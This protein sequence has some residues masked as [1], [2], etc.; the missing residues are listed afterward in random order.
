[1]I[2]FE[3]NVSFTVMVVGMI[4]I[5][6]YIYTGFMKF[7]NKD[8]QI[9]SQSSHILTSYKSSGNNREHLEFTHEWKNQQ[10]NPEKAHQKH[11]RQ[12]I[13]YSILNAC[14]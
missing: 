2:A 14:T 4:T 10:Q 3:I 9:I 11:W 5:F 7:L 6:M 8:E 12:I 13:L 1:M